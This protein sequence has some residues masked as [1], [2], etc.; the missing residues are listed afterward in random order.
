MKQNLL[1][2]LIAKRAG[3]KKTIAKV[4]RSN[5]V[6]IIDNLGVDISLTH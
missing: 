4:S 1:M 3:V 5:Y 6:K 2:S